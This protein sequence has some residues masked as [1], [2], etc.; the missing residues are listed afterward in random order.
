MLSRNGFF[1]I[2]HVFHFTDNSALPRRGD[3][4]YDKPGKIRTIL[5]RVNKTFSEHCSLSVSV[6]IDE[7]MIGTK[8]R[9]SFLQYMPQKPQKWGIKLWV[10]ADSSN[11]YVVAFEVYTGA[12]EN[13][14]H[15][16]AYSVVMK[17]MAPYV[18]LWHRLYVDNFY[19]SPLL[20]NDL[21]NDKILACGIVR[22]NRRGLPVSTERLSQGEAEF[23]KCRELTFVHWKDKGDVLCLST[24]HSTQMEP[25]VTRR[26]DSENVQHPLLITDYNKN[27]GGVDRMDQLLTYYSAGCKTI[28]WYKRLFWR[29]IDISVF[30]SFILYNLCHRDK[31]LTQKQFRL[32]IANALVQ[33]LTSK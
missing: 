13:V 21:F 16:L 27:M 17:L 10:L 15:G 33:K 4:G 3:P 14:Q 8:G 25:I 12:T 1:S 5:D 7:Q 28:K 18:G 30:N 19:T 22:Q 24:F 6:P 9:L 2:Q 26:R 31:P 20:F 32:E 23:K 11:G 29:V